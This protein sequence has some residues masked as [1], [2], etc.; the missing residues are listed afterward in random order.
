MKRLSFLALL[1]AVAALVGYAQPP[2]INIQ[3]SHTRAD[4]GQQMYASYCASCHGVDGRG[5]GAMAASIGAHPTDLTQ[6]SR[7]NHGVF[8]E[9][10]LVTV[11]RH[12]VEGHASGSKMM[13]DWG[14]VLYK[15]DTSMGSSTLRSLRIANLIGYIKTLQK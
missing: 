8:P 4:N 7:D 11:L 1:A 5:D 15:L 3:A 10:H 9:S 14:P 12:G 2:S 6:L 13:P